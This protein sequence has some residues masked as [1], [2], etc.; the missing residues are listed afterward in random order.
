MARVALIVFGTLLLLGSYSWVSQARAEP[1]FFTAN[2]SGCH[3]PPTP[4]TCDGCHS[5]GTH[6]NSAKNSINIAGATDKTSYAPGATVSVRITGGYR[7]NQTPGAWVRALLYDQNMNELARSTGPN[8]MG[9][10]SDFPITLTAPAPSAPGNYTWNVAW[11]GNQFDSGP[12]G[13]QPQFGPRWTPDPNN[14]NHGQEIVATNAFTVA[15]PAAP[16]ISLSPASLPFGSVAVGSS[17]TLDA[18]IQNTGTA[19]LDVSGIAPSAGT[20]A[21][22]S[23]RPS[24]PVSVPPGGSITLSVTYTPTAAGTDTGSFAIASNA[25]GSPASLQV[26]GTGSV[27][28]PPA[29]PVISLGLA[30][31]D[32]GQ[33]T[34]GGVPVVRTTSIQNTTGTAPLNVTGIGLC[35]GTSKEFS[36]SPAPPFTVAPGSSAALTGTYTPADAGVDSGCF[37]IASNDPAHPSVN[38]ALSGTASVPPPAAA[39]AIRLNPASLSFGTVT[40]G[41]ASV[42]Q[43]AAIQNTGTAPLSISGVALCSGTSA[44]FAWT[45]VAAPLTVAPGASTALSVSYTPNAAGTDSGCLAIASNDPSASS[46]NLAVS[47]AGSA[48]TVPPS[49]PQASISLS[50]GTLDFGAVAIGGSATRTVTLTDSGTGPLNVSGIALCADTSA[51]YKLSPSAPFTVAAGGKQ[52]LSV[53]YTPTSA[54]TDNGCATIAS[55]DPVA[56]SVN[57]DLTANALEPPPTSGRL[58]LDIRNFR[59]TREAKLGGP[60]RFRL[61]VKNSGKVAGEAEATLVGIQLASAGPMKTSAR[62]DTRPSARGQERDQRQA[63][64]E[65]DEQR[66]SDE[67][68]ASERRPE[69]GQQFRPEEVY[70]ETIAVSAPVGG[71]ST[72]DFP[73]YTI[74]SEGDIRWVVT[75]PGQAKATARTEVEE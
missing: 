50:P 22:Y 25:A 30:T 31:L 51:E 5:H 59:A 24:A 27:P 21:E 38:L 16:A 52:T 28:P 36:F 2:C 74:R 40:V 75:I 37:A 48:P 6:A 46:V 9:G 62:D 64:D 8:H 57:L 42:V 33:T 15:A 63:G 32:F 23:F 54:G 58:D 26:T 55:N 4:A 41:G 67:K 61:V 11:Y 70:R 65:E 44:E 35:A 53:T 17:V 10:G 20:S 18:A 39:P 60:V 7:N 69:R 72:F 13:T 56:P 34:L 3:A 12:P 66:K 49:N 45:S 29:A 1:S 73:P 68:S 19:P 14:P 71:T 43:S 47:G